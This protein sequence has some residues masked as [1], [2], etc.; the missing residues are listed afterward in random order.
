MSRP[1]V[2]VTIVLAALT[3]LVPA[4]ARADSGPAA[5]RL[6]DVTSVGVHNTFEKHRYPFLSD[7]LDA[8]AGLIEL[9][10]WTNAAGP[11]WRVSHSNPVANDNNCAGATSA[12][13]LRTGP[14]DQ[15]LSGCLDDLRAWHDA[16]PDHRPVVV[17]VEMKDGFTP[18]FGR[19][20]R[21][22]DALVR[23]RL[24]DAVFG[25]A[26]LLAHAGPSAATLDDAVRSVG[27]PDVDDLRGRF[28]VEL[29]P[30][31]VQENNP[32]DTWWIDRAYATHL[33]DL[34]RVGAL[35]LATA[36]PAVHRAQAGDP[37]IR[38]D[39]VLRPWFVVFDV[40]AA[41]FVGRDIDTGWYRD[42][43]YLVVLTDAH[44]VLP[45][46][47]AVA[48]SEADARTRVL[49]LAGRSASVVSTD[50][51]PLPRILSMVTDRG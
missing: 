49:D 26:D 22:F 16:D 4:T 9:D 13:Q 14:R 48:P 35:D 21:E 15:F 34:S 46:L 17:K 19:G 28:L 36:F 18:P 32:L 30:G 25:P 10:V 2:I 33:S 12:D 45:A 41:D 27:W 11:D 5:P 38:Y 43:G 23:S 37:R 47:D 50:W 1:S 31:T 3:A 40:D 44:K 6:S 7:A 24:G 42:N 39:A 8:G 20:P 29:I 51:T